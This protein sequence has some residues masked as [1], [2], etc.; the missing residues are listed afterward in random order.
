[1]TD[2]EIAEEEEQ[3][4]LENKLEIIRELD[5]IEAMGV[6][7]SFEPSV[8]DPEWKLRHE[9]ERH[10]AHQTLIQ[11]VA[12]MKGIIK[13]GSVVLEAVLS[14]FLRLKNWSKFI[15]NELDS[16]RYDATLEQVYRTIWRRGAPNPWISL[17][18]F[19]FGSAIAFHF[20]LARHDASENNENE[21]GGA[22]SP[23]S[24]SAS[25]GGGIGGSLMGMVTGMFGGGGGGGNML[26]GMMSGMASAEMPRRAAR[27]SAERT[28]E[29]QAPPSPPARM[30]PPSP[31]PQRP[32]DSAAPPRRRPRIPMPT[33]A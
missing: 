8:D 25:S 14:T 6:R 30:R 11:R 24:T 27:R 13:L 31:P 33:A 20:G 12:L 19:V 26:S 5:K 17:C 16:G 4:V 28:R 22:S 23:G 29:R 15:A 9:L 3:M 2:S 21:P 18:I 32:P 10:L 1:M 7:L